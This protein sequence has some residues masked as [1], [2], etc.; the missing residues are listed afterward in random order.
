MLVKWFKKEK[1][2][3][4]LN[5]SVSNY[6]GR[7]E[8]GRERVRT[9]DMNIL[10]SEYSLKWLEKGTDRG[11]FEYLNIWISEYCLKCFE[12]RK[13]YVNKWNKLS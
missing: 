13:W 11:E 9:R 10:I 3:K 12:K 4:D 5:I 8:G 6:W 2:V 7:R 1:S